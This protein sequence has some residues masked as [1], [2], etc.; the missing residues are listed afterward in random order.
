ME[1]FCRDNHIYSAHNTNIITKTHN[2]N[3]QVTLYIY[4]MKELHNSCNTGTSGLPDMS[5]LG[6][7]LQLLNVLYLFI[8]IAIAHKILQ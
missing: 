6:L 3:Q 8:I 7:L 1:G 2:Q 5:T 4:I